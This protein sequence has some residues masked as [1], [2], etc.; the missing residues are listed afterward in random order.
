MKPVP[1]DELP[2]HS[3]WA[4]HLLDP[5]SAPPTDPEEYTKTVTYD[6]IYSPLLDCY[7]RNSTSFEDFAAKV[8]SKGRTNPDVISIDETL[9]LA[10]TSELLEREHAAVRDTLRPVLDGGETVVDLG[11]GWGA[12]LGVI[13]EEYPD[14]T[15][16][17]GEVS[18]PGVELARTL[19][20]DAP[21]ISVERFDFHGDWHLLNGADGDDVVVFTRGALTTLENIKRIVGRLATRASTDDVVSGVHLEQTGPHPDTVLGLLRRRYAEVRNYS[22]DLLSVL[23]EHRDISVTDVEYD[24]IGANPLHP[25][26][27]VRWQPT[28]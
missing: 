20:S 26:T 21:R 9:F 18:E 10:S 3:A 23:D 8:K 24:V 16:V 25:L 7:R 2:N 12:T 1:I 11:C 28:R 19:H 15:V 27:A 6:D 22:A 17:G 13:A 5:S 4:A 14:V